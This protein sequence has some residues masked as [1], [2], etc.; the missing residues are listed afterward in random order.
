MFDYRDATALITGASS[1]LGAVFASALAARGMHLI[2]VARSQ[3]ALE[4]LARRLATQHG[5]YATAIAADLAD[6]EAPDRIRAGVVERG[7]RVDLLVNNAGFGLGGAFLSHDLAQET[8]QIQVD[9]VAL[10]ALTH[11]FVPDMVGRQ[12]GGVINLASITAFLPLAYAAVYAATKSFV[13]SFSEALGRE[14]AAA[15]VQVLAV[16]PGPVMTKFYAALGAN[17]PSQALDPPEQIVADALKAFDRRQRVVIPGR[18]RIRALAF[19]TRLLPR[20]INARL[21]E[22]LARQ[23][24]L[25]PAEPVGTP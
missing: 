23:Y 14:V 15:G 10:V 6:P 9:L 11:R 18:F 19:S 22:Q 1:G 25:A 2:L 8:A 5:I 4:A 7:L 20:A 21:G 16:C 24:F 17:P 12:Q 13:L 3:P